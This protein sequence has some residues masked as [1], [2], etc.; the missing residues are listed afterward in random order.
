MFSK[1]QLL[2]MF[3]RCRTIFRSL[4]FFVCLFSVLGCSDYWWSRGQA[5]GVSQLLERSETRLNDSL[6]KNSSSRPLLSPVASQVSAGL[7]KSLADLDAISEDMPKGA[8]ANMTALKQS[9]MQME[10]LLSIGSRAAYGEL[11]GQLRTF[12]GA[13]SSG[14]KVD[15]KAFGLFAARTKFFLANEL[16]VPA[17]NF[18]LK[19]GTEESSPA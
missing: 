4:F 2:H 8:G 13:L 10:G 19:A 6:G 1:H 14:K 17:P 5:P 15:P 11:A 3:S 18:G 9:F 7:K 12:S 16:S